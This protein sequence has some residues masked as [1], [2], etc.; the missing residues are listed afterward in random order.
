MV[1]IVVSKTID[2]GSSPAFP[3]FLLYGCFSETMHENNKKL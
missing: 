3:V 2:A 1:S